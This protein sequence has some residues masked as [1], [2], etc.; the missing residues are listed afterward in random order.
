MDLW[1]VC[2]AL[3]IL[4]GNLLNLRRGPRGRSRRRRRR[5]HRRRRRPTD[6]RSA[7]RRDLPELAVGLVGDDVERT[8]GTL[9]HIAD[10]L[11]AVGQQ[12]LLAE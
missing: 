3:L 11:S 10:A 7:P 12:V 9:A 4:G 8:V 2:G 6:A 1:T 5:S